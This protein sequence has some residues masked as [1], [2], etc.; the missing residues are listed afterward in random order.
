MG[1]RRWGRGHN[2]HLA[3]VGPNCQHSLC[4]QGKH[5]AEASELTLQVEA[6]EAELASAGDQLAV[7]QRA[8]QEAEQASVTGVRVGG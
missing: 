6:K 5:S 8:L 3:S 7:Q 4:V 1:V 2:D